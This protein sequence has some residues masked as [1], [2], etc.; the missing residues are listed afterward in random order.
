MREKVVYLDSSVIIKRYIEEPGSKYIRQLY[1][2]A[3][4][5]LIKISFSFWNISEV[6][7]VLDKSRTEEIITDEE[8]RVVKKRF[9]CETLRLTKQGYIVVIIPD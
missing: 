5:G 8:Y 3:Y 7:G 2:Q 9:L 4:N 1:I 6:L